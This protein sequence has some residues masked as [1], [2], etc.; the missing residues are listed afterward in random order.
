[1]N[2]HHDT[3]NVTITVSAFVLR[4]PMLYEGHE[5]KRVLVLS[6]PSMTIDPTYAFEIEL[7]AAEIKE[8]IGG[9]EHRCTP[10][11]LPFLVST[12]TGTKQPVQGHKASMMLHNVPWILVSWE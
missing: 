10:G 9:R 7:G 5:G 4:V 3:D 11:A 8:E 6:P 1:M 2:S 12:E